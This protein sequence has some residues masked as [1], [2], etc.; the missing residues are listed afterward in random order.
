M[1][2]RPRLRT[3]LLVSLALVTATPL[4]GLGVVEVRRWRDAGRRDADKE[5]AFTAEALARAIGQSVDA[6][7]RALETSAGELEAHPTLERA[8]LQN[9]VEIHRRRFPGLA[10]V[11]IAGADGR[12]LA[13][14]P[15]HDAKRGTYI[16]RDYADREYYRQM[17]RTGRTG[18][19]EVELGKVSGKPAIHAKTPIRALDGS[20]RIIGNMGFALALDHLQKLTSDI[21]S[22]FE[23]IEARVVDNRRRL[24]TESNPEGRAVLRDLSGLPLYRAAPSVGVELRDGVDEQGRPVRAALARVAEQSLNWTVAATRSTTSIAA[25]AG[26][27]RVT[28]L[29]A[30]VAALG[31]G[32]GLALVLSFWLARPIVSLEAYA[33]RVRSG[34]PGTAPATTASHPR[35]VTTLIDTVESMVGELRARHSEL[36]TFR[37][38]LEERI[39][40]RTAELN[41]RT[42][43]MRLLLDNLT[44]GVFTMDGAGVV[45]NGHSEVLRRWFG[46]PRG[47]PFYEYLGRQSPAFRSHAELAW[48]QVV[49]NLLGVDVALGQLPKRLES[50]GRHF[51]LFYRPI[52]D[53]E[54][55]DASRENP[56]R[57]LVVVSEI[58][59]DVEREKMLRERRETLALFEHVLGDRTGFLTFID[60]ASGMVAR[61]LSP[62]VAEEVVRRDLHTLKGNSLSFGI[63]SVGNLCHDIESAIEE[64]GS[65]WRADLVRLGE[66]WARLTADIDRLL[67]KRRRVIEISPEQHAALE[68]AARD[69]AAGQDLLRMIREVALDPIERRLRRLGQ[70]AT[71][72]AHRLG[73]QIAV[74]LTYDDIRLAAD[75]WSPFWAA[76]VHALRNAVDHGIESPEE[77][78]ALG[79]PAA[80]RIALRAARAPGGLVVEIEDDGRG[81]DWPALRRSAAARGI[82]AGAGTES[83][84]LLFQDGVSSAGQVT[85]TSGRGVGMGALRAAVESLGGQIAVHSARGA[86]TRLTITFAL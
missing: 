30:L 34:T 4:V 31:G 20:A 39:R 78:L 68:R 15:I 82:S 59:A 7:V 52:G 37:E 33:A 5:L 57:F 70:Q 73:K 58:T 49:E 38:T 80:G 8:I 72:M 48:E 46:S 54:D 84:D 24:I 74:E 21:V 60:E 47:E 32:L 79:K 69:G 2:A 55:D 18:I 29:V 51:S 63:E 44:E 65:A 75:R 1:V 16:G 76:F 45:G 26:H 83:I 53:G 22:N 40:Q 81:V 56:A 19:S 67:G 36:E 28:A 71:E 85:S 17:V 13:S 77:R 9:I 10:V 35:E 25:R 27:A 50:D 66:R 6:N 12:T 23:G 11:N 14:D 43:E 41:Q 86:G 42:I 62:G 61:L 64:G 3:Y